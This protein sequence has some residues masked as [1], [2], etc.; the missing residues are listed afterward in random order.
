MLQMFDLRFEPINSPDGV[1]NT[2]KSWQSC[3]KLWRLAWPH[4]ETPIGPGI[5]GRDQSRITV[6]VRQP[7]VENTVRMRDFE[8]WLESNGRELRGKS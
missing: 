5:I 8:A 1:E 7:E 6:V 4:L 3:T 2:P